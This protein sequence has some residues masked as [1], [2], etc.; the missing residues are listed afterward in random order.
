MFHEL[1]QVLGGGKPSDDLLLAEWREDFAKAMG[2]FSDFVSTWYPAD[3]VADKAD[4]DLVQVVTY[5]AEEVA[6]WAKTIIDS[7]KPGLRLV[8]STTA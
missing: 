8:G 3:S 6:Q 1:V 5:L 7:R 2:R 4:D